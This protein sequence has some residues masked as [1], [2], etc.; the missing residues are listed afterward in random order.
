MQQLPKGL[1]KYGFSTDSTPVQNENVESILNFVK[2]TFQKSTKFYKDHTSY[3]LKELVEDELKTYVAN[4][5][6]IAAMIILGFEY[7]K[8]G[9]GSP[10]VWFK[11]R[12]DFI[13]DLMLKKIVD[14]KSVEEIRNLR[15]WRYTTTYS[16]LKF[17]GLE[18]AFDLKLDW[19]RDHKMY[20]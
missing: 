17:L 9:K 5:D 3:S 6:F 18:K 8:T 14:S 15:V 4:G 16:D 10:N 12:P 7:K 19:L 2:S 1:Y 11:I 20:V 13:S